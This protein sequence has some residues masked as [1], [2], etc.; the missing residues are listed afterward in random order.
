MEKLNIK[1][2]IHREFGFTI[3]FLVFADLLVHETAEENSSEMDDGDAGKCRLKGSI[4][5]DKNA[6]HVWWNYQIFIYFLTVYFESEL[7][8]LSTIKHVKGKFYCSKG[9]EEI[10]IPKNKR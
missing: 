7:V 5:F 6:T 1:W 10:F 3:F 4:H 8:W 9:M 2:S